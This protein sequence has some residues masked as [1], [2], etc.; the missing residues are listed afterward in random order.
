MPLFLDGAQKAEWAGF[1]FPVSEVRIVG[2]ARLHVHEFQHQDGGLLEPLGR[3]PYRIMMHVVY[4]EGDQFYPGIYPERLNDIRFLAESGTSSKLVVPTVGSIQAFCPKWDQLLRVASSRSG[5]HADYEF[6]E[7]QSATLKQVFFAGASSAATMQQKTS[8]LSAMKLAVANLGADPTLIDK[9]VSASNDV[10]AIRD[11]ADLTAALA[12]D[13]IASLT[14]ALDALDSAVT[15]PVGYDVL[16]AARQLWQ[17]L[18]DFENDVANVIN[19]PSTWLVPAQMD[20]GTIS[21]TLYGDT[22]HQ[23]DIL[24]WNVIEDAF[25]VPAGT[26]IRYVPLAA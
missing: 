25:A 14:S 13:K 7:D 6:I 12:A 9:I 5:Q 21:R 4:D 18:L 24:V 22:D 11:R 23:T 17:T 20:I 15:T 26:K 8:D 1:P 19:P 10:L 2:E 16:E 3:K